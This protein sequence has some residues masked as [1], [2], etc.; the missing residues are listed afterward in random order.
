MRSLSEAHADL[1]ARVDKLNAEYEP[2]GNKLQLAVKP[3]DFLT[4]TAVN[5][6][7]SLAERRAKVEANPE[8]S[9]VLITVPQAE[10]LLLATA[11][12]A[13]VEDPH[14]TSPGGRGI[15]VADAATDVGDVASYDGSGETDQ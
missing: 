6:P 14:L 9:H 3:S 1:S 5:C 10:A 11:E 13:Q 7:A 4:L 2:A 12:V 15:V 8:V